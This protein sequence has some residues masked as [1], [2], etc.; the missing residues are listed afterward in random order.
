MIF[1]IK[2]SRNDKHSLF[3]RKD[4][5]STRSR[6]K[7]KARLIF[8]KIEFSNLFPVSTKVFGK[9]YFFIS[10]KCLLANSFNKVVHKQNNVDSKEDSG[11]IKVE[12]FFRKINFNLLFHNG[13]IPI[14]VQI[15]ASKKSII[16]FWPAFEKKI[17]RRKSRGNTCPI[18][19]QKII[20]RKNSNF[21]CIKK[22]Y[23]GAKCIKYTQRK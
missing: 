6:K 8:E 3:Y 2:L 14:F 22:H 7:S 21:S 4:S 23:S 5:S 20:Q 11:K 12:N 17:L 10:T 1:F 19:D 9:R 13:P 15:P 16:D 18:S